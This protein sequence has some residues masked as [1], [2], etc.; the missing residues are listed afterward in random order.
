MVPRLVYGTF[1]RL[2]NLTNL[3]IWKK[4]LGLIDKS[5]STRLTSYYEQRSTSE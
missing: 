1:T 4:F 2:Q 3:K 5:V